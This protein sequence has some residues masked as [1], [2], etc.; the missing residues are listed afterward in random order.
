[1][2]PYVIEIVQGETLFIELAIKDEDGGAVDLGPATLS[3][4]T[5]DGI[6]DAQ[7]IGTKGSPSSNSIKIRGD[8]SDT[9]NWPPG[10]FTLQAWLD[11]GA[12]AD[13]EHEI[14]FEAQVAVRRKS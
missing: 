3:I 11:W 4:V 10:Q 5:S 6:T 14:I 1:M 7:V 12:A 13:V 9:T 2:A 8:G